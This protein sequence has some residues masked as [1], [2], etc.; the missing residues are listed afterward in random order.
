V[1]F[2]I[3]IDGRLQHATIDRSGDADARGGRFR[4][5]LRA[6]DAP[7]STPIDVDARLT[8]LGWSLLFAD[9]RSVD[10]ALT[11]QTGGGWFVQLPHTSCT[12]MVDGRRRSGGA[13]AAAGTGVQRI[14]APMPGRVVKVLV[15]PGDEVTAKQGV[16]VVEAMKMENELSSARAGRVK[17]VAVAEGALVEAGRLLV[18]IE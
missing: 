17:E 7:A 9:G 18:V 6:A 12:A 1:T 14:L 2:D 8:D 3:E 4:V 13:A 15:K 11:E 5:S 10:I 16:V